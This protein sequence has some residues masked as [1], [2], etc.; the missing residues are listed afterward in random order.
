MNLIKCP[1]NHYYDANKFSSCPHCNLSGQQGAPNRAAQP[2]PG[3]QAPQPQMNQAPQMNQQMQRPP[4]PPQ[5][6]NLGGRPP[7]QQNNF[8]GQRPPVPPQQGMPS[9]P[10]AGGQINPGFPPQQGMVPTG[11]A[12][13][14]QGE[15]M[16]VP[17]QQGAVVRSSINDDVTVP[18]S[19]TNSVKIEIKKPDKPMETLSEA[20]NKAN[21]TSTPSVNEGP[22]DDDDQHTIGYYDSPDLFSAGVQPVVGWLVVLTGKMRGDSINIHTGRSFI[23]RGK[24]NDIVIDGDKSI[25]REKHAVVVFEPKNQTFLLQPGSS[26]E[27]FY[28]NGDVVLDTKELEA[29]DRI[30]IGK[31]KLL[32]IPLCGEKFSW[33]EE[34][35]ESKD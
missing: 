19:H 15:F 35:E 29:Y 3:Q 13:N 26:R 1:N 34:Q 7:M 20:L 5:Q 24:S 21:I 33:D 18:M 12:D 30:E 11:P 32:F 14:G 2:Q 31:T 17:A 6:N 23:G 9:A 8:G 10:M 27:L 16:T 22:N 4:V 25:S 28:L